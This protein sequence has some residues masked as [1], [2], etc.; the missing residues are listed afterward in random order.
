MVYEIKD[1]NGLQVRAKLV[2]DEEYLEK[3][4]KLS[5]AELEE[6]AWEDIKEINKT[7]PVYKY[8]KAVSLTN[9]EFEKTTTLKIKRHIELEKIKKEN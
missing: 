9:Q 7:L 5:L 8:I 1:K 2:Y 6:K 4:L 3:E